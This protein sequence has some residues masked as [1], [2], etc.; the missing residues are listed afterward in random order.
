MMS[1]IFSASS[2][3]YLGLC[4]AASSVLSYSTVQRPIKGFA[5]DSSVAGC[6][7][8]DSL[9]ENQHKVR[10]SPLLFLAILVVGVVVVIVHFFF[11]LKK[12]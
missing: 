4:L 3:R 10:F 7:S 1:G 5:A 11:S 12:K 2:G 6:E 9:P 8:A